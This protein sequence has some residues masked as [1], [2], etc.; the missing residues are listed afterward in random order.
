MKSIEEYN[1]RQREI[2]VA[3][4]D[5]KSSIEDHPITLVKSLDQ[6]AMESESRTL[7]DSV[8][9]FG[10]LVSK[11]EIDLNERESEDN[12]TI[13]ANLEQ[14]RVEVSDEV[15]AHKKLI[16]VKLEAKD[17]ARKG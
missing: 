3:K 10:N 6:Q 7:N 12:A 4:R 2:N 8:K 11:L 14:M 16:D 5:V 1:K 17:A 15:L 13:L 9:T